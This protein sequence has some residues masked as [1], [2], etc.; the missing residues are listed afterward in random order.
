LNATPAEFVNDNVSPR[1]KGNGMGTIYVAGAFSAPADGANI[2][3]GTL[4]NLDAVFRLVAYVHQVIFFIDGDA[5]GVGEK[6]M[7][8]LFFIAAPN[9]DQFESQLSL[10]R[11]YLFKGI[12]NKHRFTG[13]TG[14]TTKNSDHNNQKDFFQFHLIDS[15]ESFDQVLDSNK[16][17]L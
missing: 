7:F 8:I 14:K 3:A 10:A 12:T 13:C 9:P 17:S 15:P 1:G 5:Y 2:F 6:L 11:F 4:K 16:K